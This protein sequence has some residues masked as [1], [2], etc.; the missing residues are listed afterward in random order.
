MGGRVFPEKCEHDRFIS[1]GDFI[2]CTEGCSD[3]GVKP[4]CQACERT[5]ARIRFCDIDGCNRTD[6]THVHGYPDCVDL[7]VSHKAEHDQWED[8]W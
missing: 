5:I 6:T 7:C 2:T 3:C 4:Y 8:A 1:G